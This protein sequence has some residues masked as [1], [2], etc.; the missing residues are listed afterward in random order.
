M[1]KVIDFL[2]K[3]HLIPYIIIISLI[4][5]FGYVAKWYNYSGVGAILGQDTGAFYRYFN[6]IFVL[7]L[8][9]VTVVYYLAV[10]KKAA[11]E[12]LYVVSAG[13]IGIIFMLIVPPYASADEDRHLLECQDFSSAI[14][15]YEMEGEKEH[16]LRECDANTELS[17]DLSVK[18]YQYVAENFFAGCDSKEMELKYIDDITYD[19][20]NVV[21]Y[22]PGIIGITIG[23]LFN[24]GTIATYMLAR[25][26]M[27]VTYLVIT[28]FAIKKIPVF[29]AGYAILMLLPSTMQRAATVSYDGLM[30][31]YIFIFVA[32][33]FYYIYNV[34]TIKVV[35]AVVM[36][37]SGVLLAVGKGG[38]YIPFLLMLFMIPKENFGKKVKYG[39]I[40][41]GAILLCLVAFVGF[42]YELFA[43]IAGSTGGETNDLLWTEEE[44]YTL[45]EIITSPKRSLKVF[46]NTFI[47]LGGAK[48]SEM[49]GN[50]FGWLQVYVSDIWVVAFSILIVMTLFNE[51][52]EN[53][54]FSKKQKLM[55]G[56]IAVASMGFV[57]LS[58]WLFWTPLNSSYIEGLQGRYFIPI[59]IPLFFILKNKLFSVQRK[60]APYLVCSAMIMYV[61]VFLDIWCGMQL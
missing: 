6:V 48:Y 43:D 42:N 61:G 51:S 14:F 56:V 30:L 57:I 16:W 11:I 8:L 55:F 18:N 15:G 4:G 32:Y 52:G 28:Y 46:I 45:R 13:F 7:I 25:V 40:V 54:T 12:K 31:A 10:I 38:A 29:K 27:L 1:K 53:F 36:A 2:K 39:F 22:Y 9:A 37:L 50:G 41:A 47:M 49:I 17:R 20:D 24:M 58:M 33:V 26:F 60:V 21:Y 3:Y 19:E 5:I 35:D 34:K 23:R 44:G 59:L